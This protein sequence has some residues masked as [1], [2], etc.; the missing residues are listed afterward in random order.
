MKRPWNLIDLPVYSLATYANGQTNMNICTYVTA[1]SMQPKLY[2][3][4]IYQ[5]TKTL[6]NMY[7]QEKA[8]LQLLHPLQYN[9][10]KYLGQKSGRNMDKHAY[11]QKR[12][13]LQTWHGYDVLQGCA[14]LILL[15]KIDFKPTGDHVLF[16][17]QVEAFN[18]YETDILGT[19]YLKQKNIIRA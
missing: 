5:D 2:A 12:K 9:M 7:T 6:D 3:I 10:V 16:T 11:L 4:A 8:V 14:A 18:S 17:F 1:I 19:H 13:C 15:Q